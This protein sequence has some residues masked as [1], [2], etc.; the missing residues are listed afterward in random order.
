MMNSSEKLLKA[1]SSYSTIYCYGAGHW[2]RLVMHFLMENNISIKSFLVSGRN[3]LDS[4]CGI[5]IVTLDSIDKD[6][7]ADSLILLS[8]TEPNHAA[9]KQAIQSKCAA[10]VIFPIVSKMIHS[11][12]LNVYNIKLLESIKAEGEY[13]AE[14]TAE[15]EKK[16]RSIISKYKKVFLRYVFV[17]KIGYISLGWIF[18][19][20]IHHPDDEYWVFY[21]GPSP[22]QANEFLVSKIMNMKFPD[23]DFINALSIGFWKYFFEKYPEYVKVDASGASEEFHSQLN[24]IIPYIDKKKQP[25]LIDFTEEEICKGNLFLDQHHLKEY[26]CIF[27]RDGK[28]TQE[29][30]G[31]VDKNSISDDFYRDMPIGDFVLTARYLSEK[32]VASVRMGSM[33]EGNAPDII[34]DYGRNYHTDF[35]DV[36]LF[37]RCRYFIGTP[38]GVQ[39]LA[40]FFSKPIVI[41]NSPV[42]STENSCS[43]VGRDGNLM[44]PQKYWDSVNSRYLTIREMLTVECFGE[45][46]YNPNA[47]R[48]TMG[49]YHQRKILPIK[50]TPEE[51]LAV[52]KEMEEILAGTVVYDELDLELQDKYNKIVSEFKD[53][54][55]FI[56]PYRLGRDFLRQ[57]QWILE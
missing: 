50:N 52:A 16:A 55:N 51:I 2:G 33:P 41:V 3:K 23:I 29:W 19:M 7:M 18:Y 37:S 26:V 53:A 5:P 15:Y 24:K 38:S 40:D 48:R 32:D 9:V 21:P 30:G 46:E 6:S 42:L 1:C 17:T 27:A 22:R 34:F 8:L 25:P 45:A 28:Y 14:D 12:P 35:L 11:I 20:N 49:I 54:P 56:F 44:I 47:P 4:Y 36:F 10:S 57:N 13:L 43:F 31:Y 39:H